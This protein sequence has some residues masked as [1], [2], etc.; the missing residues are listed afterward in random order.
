MGARPSTGRYGRRT[1]VSPSTAPPSAWRTGEW[2]LTGRR[3]IAAISRT[4]SMARVAPAERGAGEA[5][6]VVAV[7]TAAGAAAGNS[8]APESIRRAS[9]AGARDHLLAPS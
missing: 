7:A 6:A 2:Q 1:S 5:A 4:A 3:A 8:P 9:L